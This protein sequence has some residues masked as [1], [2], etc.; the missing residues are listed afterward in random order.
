MDRELQSLIVCLGYF[1]QS[2]AF[3]AA[4]NHVLLFFRSLFRTASVSSSF[5]ESFKS[6]L[7]LFAGLL[8]LFWIFIDLSLGFTQPLSWSI[9]LGFVLQFVGLV[10]ISFSSVFQSNF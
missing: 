9:F 1:F 2:S 10:V 4:A 3:F 5:T 7:H 6:S 8:A